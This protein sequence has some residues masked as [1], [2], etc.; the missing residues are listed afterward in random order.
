M[1]RAEWLRTFVAVYRAGS[2]T[3]GA[4]RRDLSQP[5]ASQQLESLARLAGDLVP[6]EPWF[7]GRRAT[8]APDDPGA[9]VVAALA[10]L[11]G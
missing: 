8:A 4:R 5:A 6:P 3:E 10:A 2:V 7:A 9:A 1:A 11:A